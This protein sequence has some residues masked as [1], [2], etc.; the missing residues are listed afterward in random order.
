MYK[1]DIF[2]CYAH[3]FVEKGTINFTIV[4]IGCVSKK[5]KKNIIT[6]KNWKIIRFIA[7]GGAS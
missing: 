1:I 3:L 4:M 2:K 6:A 7:F 5:E